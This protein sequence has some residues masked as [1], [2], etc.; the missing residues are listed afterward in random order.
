MQEYWVSAKKLGQILNTSYRNIENWAANN[1]IK[2]NRE[3]KYG[4]ISAFKYSLSESSAELDRVKKQLDSIKATEN[5]KVELVKLRK[6]VAEAN[7]EEAI[8]RIKTL[9][10]D[11]REG[12]LVNAE[13]VLLSWENL[14]IDC[15]AK[16]LALPVKL[17]L[18]LSGLDNPEEI[19]IKLTEVIDEALRELVK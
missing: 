5:E 9:E 8:A 15:K 13:E 6:L 16:L 7:K 18:E 12:Q 2:Q 1:R 11:E 17:A 10:A 3:G 4:L 19:Q 14:I